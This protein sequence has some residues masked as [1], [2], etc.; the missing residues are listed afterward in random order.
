MGITQM[1][2]TERELSKNEL[3]KK[4]QAHTHT[5]THT[6]TERERERERD[7]DRDRETKRQRDRERQRDKLRKNKKILWINSS[8]SQTKYFQRTSRY[9]FII[10]SD[11]L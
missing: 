7:R 10:R 4:C 3:I 5:H 1:D 2:Y 8:Y 9:L 11:R 6:H